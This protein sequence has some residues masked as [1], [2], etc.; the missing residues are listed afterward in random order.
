MKN[1]IL[2]IYLPVTI[3]ASV[4]LILL[5]WGCKSETTASPYMLS[6]DRYLF[7]TSQTV[8]T[9]TLIESGT[10]FT[11]EPLTYCSNTKASRVFTISDD[12]PFCGFADNDLPYF[13][14]YTR[15][16]ILRIFNADPIMLDSTTS[17]LYWWGDIHLRASCVTPNSDI[18]GYRYL[19]FVLPNDSSSKILSMQP[20]GT[21]ALLIQNHTVTLK[22]GDTYKYFARRETLTVNIVVPPDTVPRNHSLLVLDSLVIHNYG[23]QSKILVLFE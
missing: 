14:F 23:L 13:K 19:P 10:I 4:S 12:C 21:A 1:R 20:D 18:I 8:T 9:Q 17:A 11:P 15:S 3:I 22:T 6:E 5:H 2:L 7:L 16:R